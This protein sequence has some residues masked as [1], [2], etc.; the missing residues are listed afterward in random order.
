MPAHNLYHDAV[1]DALVADGWT[2]TADPLR[3]PYGDH[4][5]YVDLGLAG[6][7]LVA[8]RAGREIAVEIQSFV[9]RRSSTTCT[10]RSAS[11]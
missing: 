1:I 5:R 6:S 9:G 11:A 2:V 7:A 4:G 3:L 8:G 10:G